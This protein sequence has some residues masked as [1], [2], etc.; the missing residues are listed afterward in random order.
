MSINSIKVTYSAVKP[1]KTARAGDTKVI[2][3]SLHIRVKKMVNIGTLFNPRMAYDH[4][5]GKQ[6]YEWKLV[7]EEKVE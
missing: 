5:G 1:V 2:K 4:T 3:G 6:R 7:E